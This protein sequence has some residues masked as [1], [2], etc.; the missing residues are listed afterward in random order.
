MIYLLIKQYP[1]I[2]MALGFLFTFLT[3]F[4]LINK[5]MDKLPADEGRAF[6]VEGALSRGKPRGAGF[7]FIL[8]FI[9]SVL[10]FSSVFK[11]ALGYMV[12]ILIYLLLI[13]AEMITGFLDDKAEKPW[14]RLKK[15][16]LDLF[17]SIA[18]AITYIYSN[19]TS[20]Y[21]QNYELVLPIW[22]MGIVVIAVCW[23]MINVTNCADGVDG[24]SSTLVMT[25]LVSFLIANEAGGTFGCMH[26]YRYLIVF[27]I[28]ALLAYLMF[29]AGPSML[30]MGDAGSRAMGIFLCITALKSGHLLLL[31]PFAI[32][33]ILDGGL[34]LFK[35][36][37]IKITKKKDFLS[38]IR[39]PLHDHVRKNLEKGWSNNQTVTRFWIIQIIVSIVTIYVFCR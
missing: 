1:N 20:V 30:M 36:S 24:L 29:N 6:A 25:S 11:M 33:I 27:F 23:I 14:S 17:V 31:I 28:G 9:T 39:T 16:M 26:G 34:G 12:E 37:M 3:S 2:S 7:I 21:V 19:G 18:L 8:C 5:F 4:F 32:V 10:L 13:F 22:L 38:K 35:V 15:G